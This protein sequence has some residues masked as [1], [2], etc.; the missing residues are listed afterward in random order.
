VLTSA[1]R[2]CKTRVY[3]FPRVLPFFHFLDILSLSF[4]VSFSFSFIVGDPDHS[5]LG[6]QRHFAT[7]G[8]DQTPFSFRFFDFDVRRLGPMANR[9][10]DEDGG[11]AVCTRPL[12]IR[13][14]VYT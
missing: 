4:S 11:T 6:R 13:R 9:M 10:A 1:A 8:T 2:E 14:N 5:L 3:P 12:R 7:Y